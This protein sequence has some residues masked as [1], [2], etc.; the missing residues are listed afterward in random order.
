MSNTV[1]LTLYSICAGQVVNLTRNHQCLALKQVWYSL[2]THV[3]CQTEV[4]VF[5]NSSLVL[6]AL[7]N[8]QLC[9]LDRAPEVLYS[10]C[11]GQVVNIMRNHQCLV[12]NQVWYL[13]Y[14]SP[15]RLQIEW[16]L[17]SPE[18]NSVPVATRW[19]LNYRASSF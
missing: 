6:T 4:H 17:S 13:F 1:F 5:T 19:P 14:Q 11:A 15:K 16:T 8:V 12:P 18:S 10:I 2:P 9:F 3:W 7:N